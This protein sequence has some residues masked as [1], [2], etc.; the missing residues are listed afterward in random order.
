MFFE[1]CIFPSLSLE[2]HCYNAVENDADD[3]NDDD[4]I[5]MS[6]GDDTADTD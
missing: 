2:L 3:M 4:V 5:D 6:Y 1:V